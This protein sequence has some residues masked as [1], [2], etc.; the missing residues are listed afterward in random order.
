MK[1][2]IL[3]LIVFIFNCYSCQ[4][5]NVVNIYIS[6][7]LFTEN[8]QKLYELIKYEVFKNALHIE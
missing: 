5:K 4:Q 1:K 8:W 3:L 7:N 2:L 6:G